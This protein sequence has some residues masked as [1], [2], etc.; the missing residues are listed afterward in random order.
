M[1]I[2]STEDD[3]LLTPNLSWVKGK[4][5][6]KFGADWR[7]LQDTYYQTF[8]GG[9]FSFTNLFT[10]QNALNAGASGGRLAWHP[11][12][13]LFTA[14]N[15]LNPPR[16]LLGLGASGENASSH[17]EYRGNLCTIRDTTHRTPGRQPTS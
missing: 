5:T 3:Y 14:Q 17:L 15:A 16:C 11:P 12:A 9:S 4:H 6:F 8:D 13:Q 10:A 2:L 1:H 7:D